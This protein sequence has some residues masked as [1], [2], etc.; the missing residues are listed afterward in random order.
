[1]S[2][3]AA[4][5]L[6]QSIDREG[7]ELAI[8]RQREDCLKLATAKGWETVEYVDNDKSASSGKIRPAYQRMMSDIRDGKVGA[9][10][11][12]DADRLHR[13]PRELEDFIDLANDRGIALAT[14]GG[15]FDLSTP[16]GRGNARLRGAFA[17]MEVEQKSARQL[18]AAKQKAEHG[19]P[20]WKRAFG[21]MTTPDGPVPDPAVAPLVDE[22][23]RSIISG[24]SLKSACAYL[25]D[26]GAYGL[27]GLPWNESRMAQFI[28][29]PRNAGLRAHN[30]ELV[31]GDGKCA[32]WEPLVS[33][34]RWRAAC[35]SLDTRPN[36]G[37]GKRRPMRKHLL[38]G[39]LECGKCGAHMN[40]RH[41]GNGVMGYCCT[42]CH[43]VT[44]RATDVE[45]L[46][47]KLIGQRLAREDAADLLKANTLNPDEVQAI[48]DQ[49]ADLYAELR[50]LAVDRG[51][52]LLTSEQVKIASDIVQE[53]LD[54]LERKE[55]DQERLRVLDGIPLGTPE[56]VA[57]VGRLPD[58][59]FRA[60][61]SLICRV[62]VKPVGKGSH[63]FDPRR[64][65]VDPI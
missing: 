36:G 64:I 14:V 45:P 20:Q 30:G 17:R 16:T 12:W 35:T 7:N 26:A 48:T 53:Q 44:V 34:S 61:L 22:V 19:R 54:A 51:N 10:V 9:V 11:A 28:R 21:Y 55:Q 38:S 56:A 27:N 32:T 63:V 50:Q 58:D 42:G 2:T 40:A 13:Q 3:I 23:Y 4:I 29:S 57:A 62:T 43:G 24:A 5:Y 47:L 60:V 52:K 15:E 39:L 6:R 8:A 33:E 25:N 59:R 37:R 1:M 41:R 31:N 46:M 65:V 49:K 18:R